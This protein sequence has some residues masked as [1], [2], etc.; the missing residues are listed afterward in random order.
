[1][2]A[3]ILTV[4]Y[5]LALAFGKLPIT[6]NQNLITRLGAPSVKIINGDDVTTH[7]YPYQ[8]SIQTGLFNQHQCGG[9][10]L[11]PKW[12]ITSAHC[13]GISLL[14]SRVVAG[15]YNLSDVDNE[16][17]QIRNI[18]LYSVVKHPEFE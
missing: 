6:K 9:A 2:Q 18:D 3:T 16:T 10:L 15:A 1:M 4:F 13:V 17:V 8:V 12:V 11:S 14:M 7:K 5:F